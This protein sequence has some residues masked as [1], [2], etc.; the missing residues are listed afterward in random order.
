MLVKVE[1][2]D[3]YGR[4]FSAWSE[5]RNCQ[6][7]WRY[8][9]NDQPYTLRPRAPGETVAQIRPEIEAACNSPGWAPISS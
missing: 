1:S 2:W 8:S 6:E 9:V 7:T 4:V 3:D 5:F